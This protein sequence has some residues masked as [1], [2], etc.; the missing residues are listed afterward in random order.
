M[1]SCKI[2]ELDCGTPLGVVQELPVTGN[3]FIPWLRVDTKES[4]C[5]LSAPSVEYGTYYGG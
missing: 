2:K 4:V 5:L 1:I 3:C